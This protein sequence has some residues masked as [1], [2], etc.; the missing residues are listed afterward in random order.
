MTPPLFQMFPALEPATEA[1]LRASIDRFGV[2]VPVHQDQHGRTLDGHHRQRIADELGVVY[3]VNVVEVADDDEAA[4]IARTLNTDRRHL[5]AEQRR[6]VVVELRKDGHSLRAIGDALGVSHE[7]VRK[8]LAGVNTLT[9]ADVRGRDG[10]TYPSRREIT[11]RVED[12][13]PTLDAGEPDAIADELL[14]LDQIT[15]TT[16]AAAVEDNAESKRLPIT[17]PDLGGG[18]SHPARYTDA[19]LPVFAHW[20]QREHLY[21][22]CPDDPLCPGCNGVKVLDPFAGTGRIHELRDL[23]PDVKTCG[24][25]LEPEWANLHPDTIVGNALELPFEDESFD[26]ICTSPTYGNRLADSHNASDPHLRRSYTHDLGRQL[27]DDNSGAMQWGDEYRSFHEAAWAE[28]VRVLRP[29][30]LFLLNIK[31]HIRGGEIQPVSAW[32]ANHLMH[33]HGLSLV[34][35]EIVGTPSLRQGANAD[36]RVGH[37]FVWVLRK[38]DSE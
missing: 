15:D 6:P 33:R 23:A 17:K 38:E 10:K 31:D 27:S 9:P 20:L 26:A 13:A 35:A 7:A 24:V 29:G 14:D 11:D 4:E 19:L 37:E 5:T 34:Q 8:D 2:L 28:A 1:A 16:I 32:H 25:E 18:V 3:Q 22:K 30:G 12:I 21:E 36:A